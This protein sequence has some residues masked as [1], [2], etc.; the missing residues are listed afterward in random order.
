MQEEELKNRVAK[1]FFSKYDCTRI[2]S[3]IDFSVCAPSGSTNDK[4]DRFFLWA[5]AKAVKSDVLDMLA[6][7][8][9]TIGKAKTFQDKLPPPFLGCFDIQHI[10]FIPYSEIQE[11][12]ITNDF[13]WNVTPSDKTTREFALVKQKITE[14]VG[15]NGKNP[16]SLKGKGGLLATPPEGAWVNST[17]GRPVYIF[18]FDKDEKELHTFIKENFVI[19]S[20]AVNK[21]RI[22]KNNFIFV[23]N[24]WLNKVKPT[25][26]LNWDNAKKH[27]VLDGDFYLA[28]LLSR[29]NESLKESLSVYLKQH[30]YI[31]NK[32][33]D[34][35][36]GTFA[37]ASAE[38]SDGQKAYK[39]FWAIYERPPLEEYWDYIIK[40]RDLLV[41]Q[42]IRE[43]KGSFYTPEIW[44]ELSQKYM[45]DVFGVDWQEEYYIWDCAAGTGNLLV[46]LT[47]E[48]RVYAST[49]DKAD[50]DVMQDRIHNGANLLSENIFVF[51]FLN[52]SF[53]TLPEGIQRI[54]KEKPEKLIIYINPPYA[55]AGN[56][57]QTSRTGRNRSNVATSNK[58]H[59]R[60]REK[61]GNASNELFAQFLIRA[62]IEIPNCKICQF[63]TLKTLSGPNFA[64]FREVFLAKLEKLFIVPAATFDN[65]NGQFPIGF[66]IWDTA[67]KE[68]FSQIE[69]EVFDKQGANFCS[70]TIF[71]YDNVKGLLNDWFKHYHDKNNN[72]IGILHNHKNSFQNS[73]QVHIS[74]YDTK[75]HTTP[76][77]KN[78]LLASSVYFTVRRVIP[79]TWLNDHDQYVFPNDDW[80][81]DTVFQNNCLA[82]TLFHNCNY[83]T[84]KDGVNHWIPF[85]EREVKA[86]TEFESH[87]MTDFI[88]GKQSHSTDYLQTSIEGFA[89]ER[90]NTPLVFSE[91]ANAVFDAGR[92][93]W[94]YYHS[95]KNSNPN[96]S[97]YDIREHFQGRSANGRMNSKSD[98]EMY[99]KLLGELRLAMKILGEQIKPKVYEYGFLL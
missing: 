78:N 77:T 72:K 21:I 4:I 36:F 84:S 42:D 15:N 13:N 70:K 18:D 85:I 49:I 54:I 10:V 17:K 58:I 26:M 46:G 6:Q 57:R 22:D 73:T 81:Q 23:Y 66:H 95:Q 20:T 88:S 12:F 50:I 56:M 14:I 97:F 41:P 32:H 96:A 33:I 98:D 24:K 25:I 1:D 53:D 67:K 55:E 30:L 60:Y 47:E 48:Y 71:S 43:R 94:K 92:Q 68:K 27:G 69:A 7:L 87:F 51:D 80:K 16:L 65:V 9:L 8:V 45:A 28:D 79:A 75:D 52:D 93:L 5:E 44:V 64:T 38:F 83:I 90:D 86:R 62:Y 89:F 76:I 11:I 59:K 74:T 37:S 63:S 3:K 34:Q 61:I 40:R 29:N 99:N 31:F 39:E 91:A 82:Y 35:D 2:L 19:D